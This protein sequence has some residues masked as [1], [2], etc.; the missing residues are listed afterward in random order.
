MR[1]RSR[2][3][4][5]TPLLPRSVLSRLPSSLLGNHC[6]WRESSSYHR[7]VLAQK[8]GLAG[9][10]E[11]WIWLLANFKYEEIRTF[12]PRPSDMT[13]CAFMCKQW[14]WIESETGWCLLTLLYSLCWFPAKP[15]LI[16]VNPVLMKPIKSIIGQPVKWLAPTNFWRVLKFQKISILLE[17]DLCWWHQIRGP[18]PNGRFG[19]CLSNHDLAEGPCP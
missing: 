7:C 1:R 11:G 3:A 8:A 12:T 15:L 9:W 5:H 10:M 2:W 13:S 16:S 4:P 6:C 18:L 14:S 19:A 17:Q